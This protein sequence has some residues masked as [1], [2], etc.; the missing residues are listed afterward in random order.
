[1]PK[2]KRSQ[3][4][5]ETSEIALGTP[6]HRFGLRL[7][8]MRP[9]HKQF[10]LDLNKQLEDLPSVERITLVSKIPDPPPGISEDLHGI[11]YWYV[12]KN[13]RNHSNISSFDVSLRQPLIEVSGKTVV[14]AE[15]FAED[16]ARNIFPAPKQRQVFMN[17][18]KAYAFMLRRICEFNKRTSAPGQSLFMNLESASRIGPR[19]KKYL[20]FMKLLELE[21]PKMMN[22]YKEELQGLAA[23]RKELT[24]SSLFA[25]IFKEIGG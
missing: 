22:A 1:M 2:N 7:D 25:E 14:I 21:M 15:A 17:Y 20:S 9:E 3:P 18:V 12:H 10:F 5:L 11:C 23:E 19:T 16:L 13:H 8:M 4:E 6:L 24:K